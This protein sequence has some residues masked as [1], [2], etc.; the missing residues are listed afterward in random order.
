MLCVCAKF[1]SHVLLFVTLWTVALRLLCPWDS[2]GK[3]TG[4]GCHAFLQ[5]IFPT[6]RLNP[7]ILWLLHGQVGSISL[8]HLGSPTNA[9]DSNKLNTILS[10]LNTSFSTPNLLKRECY[11]S[12]S[13]SCTSYSNLNQWSPISNPTSQLT[14]N[15]QEPTGND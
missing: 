8:S 3:N 2:L 7:H 6:Q 5:G 12:C 4:V 10:A 13:T 1:F 9:L 11:V 14:V 15:F